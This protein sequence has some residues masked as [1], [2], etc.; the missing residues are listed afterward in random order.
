MKK[1]SELFS[2]EDRAAIAAAVEQAERATSGEIVPVVATVSGRY[3]RAED[4]V[5][6]LAALLLVGL[7]WLLFQD[8]VPLG[9]DWEQGYTLA[10]PLLGVL[11][12]IVAGF[13]GGAALATAFPLLRLPF[14]PRRE[15]EEEVERRAAEAFQ[16]CRVRATAGAT[17]IL[18]Y[19]SLYERMVR[20]VGDDAIAAKLD[21]AAW[22]GVVE[23]VTA[24]MGRGDPV[25]GLNDGIRRCG[26]LLAAHFPIEP[27]DRDELPNAL[28]CLD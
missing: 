13:A 20:V 5:G 4:V 14:I 7:G 12:A 15:M 21:D 8:V 11:V 17:G 9:G 24:G 10:F 1:A 19:V 23:Q 2:G 3:D 18:V 16:R 6:L 22:A 26:E 28:V 27:G 25:G